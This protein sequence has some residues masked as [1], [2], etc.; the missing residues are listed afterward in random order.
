MVQNELVNS[1]VDA[2]TDGFYVFRMPR[3]DKGIPRGSRKDAPK[4]ASKPAKSVKAGK[5]GPGRPRLYNGKDR[6]IIAAALK[7]H[8]YTYG[9]EFLRKERALPISMTVARAVAKSEGIEFKR[10]RPAA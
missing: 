6:R 1:K 4:V 10:G 9:L 7:K 5:R 2:S 3:V 8:G